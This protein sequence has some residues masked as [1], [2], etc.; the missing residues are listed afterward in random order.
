[1]AQGRTV[2]EATAMIASLPLISMPQMFMGIPLNEEGSLQLKLIGGDA[3]RRCDFLA[4]CLAWLRYC[5]LLSE[6]RLGNSQT[7]RHFFL[8]QVQVFAPGTDRCRPVDQSD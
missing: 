6:R 3:E 1:V 5:F 8:S 2:K 7:F 4:G